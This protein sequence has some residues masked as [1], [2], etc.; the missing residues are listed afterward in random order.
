MYLFFK[1]MKKNFP[2]FLFAFLQMPCLGAGEGNSDDQKEKL[3]KNEEIKRLKMEKLAKNEEI[4]RLK[5]EKLELEK[6]KESYSDRV[7]IMGGGIHNRRINVMGRSVDKKDGC[8][9]FKNMDYM[10]GYLWI[11]VH[12]RITKIQNSG[13]N[14]ANIFAELKRRCQ[15]RR[16]IPLGFAIRLDDF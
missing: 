2:L 14:V 3:A 8:I 4:K 11:D 1:K 9:D 5:M 7:T 12:G 10:V 15:M 13:I 16:G 6:N